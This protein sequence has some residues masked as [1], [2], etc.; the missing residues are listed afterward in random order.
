MTLWN[1]NIFHVT[2]HLCGGCTGPGEFP[3]HKGQWRR[4]LMFSLICVWKNGCVNNREA[5]DL[6]SHRTHY[7]VIVK[8]LPNMGTWNFLNPIRRVLPWLDTVVSGRAE[9]WRLHVQIQLK[10]QLLITFINM[11]RYVLVWFGIGNITHIL[12]DYFTGTHF[13]VPELLVRITSLHD[14]TVTS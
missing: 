12:W 6:G 10:H 3:T 7:D 1:G 2:G 11:L 13:N 9:T 5:G 4:A 8:K 14:I